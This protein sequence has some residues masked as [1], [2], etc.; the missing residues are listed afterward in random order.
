MNLSA[1]DVTSPL[2]T[3]DEVAQILR[4]SRRTVERRVKSGELPAVRTGRK[5]SNVRVDGRELQSWLYGD[6][7]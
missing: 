6:A 7:S 2:L 4:V 1:P 3:L 5:R